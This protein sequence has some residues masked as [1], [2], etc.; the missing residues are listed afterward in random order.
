ME[1]SQAAKQA[2]KDA[3]RKARAKELKKLRKAKEKKA[4][5]E[6]TLPKNDSKTIEKQVTASTSVKGQSQLKSGVQ[7]SKED[8]IRMAQAAEREKRAAAAE[9]RIAALKIQANSATTAP[10]MSEPKSGLAGDIYC[11][12]CNSSLAGKVPFH[13]YNYKYCSTSCMHVHREILEDQ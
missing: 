7:L 8:Q 2:E 10:T 4:Q 12:C 1:E 3:K 6:A 13:R 9:K 5:V 11:S